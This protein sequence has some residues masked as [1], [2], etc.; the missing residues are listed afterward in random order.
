MPRYF[1]YFPKTLYSYNDSSVD[2]VTNLVAK[3]KIQE[4]I[5]E[6]SVIYYEYDIQDG[7]TPELIASKIYG[8]PEKHWIILTT[9]NIINPQV[10]WLM[11]QKT[12]NRYVE[13][14]Y[15]EN[16]NTSN[17]ETGLQWA[18][19]NIHSYYRIETKTNKTYQNTI[20]KKIVVDQNTYANISVSES[21]YVLNSGELINL[22]IEKE[23]KTYFEYESDLNERKRSIKIL[24]SEIVQILESE[25][26][27][28]FST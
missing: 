24:K 26:E 19:E 23:A 27:K 12:F 16:A 9:N 18:R 4:D 7:E 10:D 28:V 25:L 5:L 6:N 22:K 15:V 20:V 2:A 1:K 8:D 3:F 13:A 11:E 21:N 17:N 14:K